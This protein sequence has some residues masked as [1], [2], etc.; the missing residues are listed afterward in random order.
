MRMRLERR[1]SVQVLIELDCYH[2][3]MVRM[4]IMTRAI[5]LHRKRCYQI[6]AV[7]KMKRTHLAIRAHYDYVDCLAR[8]QHI[9]RLLIHSITTE[10]VNKS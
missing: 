3:D 10:A 2:A 5:Q 9:R 7:G 1:I 8:R 6:S 4:K